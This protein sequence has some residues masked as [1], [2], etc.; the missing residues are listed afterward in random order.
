MES[1]C[2]E[3]IGREPES[4]ALMTACNTVLN[5]RGAGEALRRISRPSRAAG[6]HMSRTGRGFVELQHGQAGS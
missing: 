5:R 4:E 3:V 2:L 1:R 6:A